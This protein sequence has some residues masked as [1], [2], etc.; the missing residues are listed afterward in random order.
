[1]AKLSWKTTASTKKSKRN[2]EEAISGARLVM[3]KMKTELLYI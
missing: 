1:M 2:E 3:K